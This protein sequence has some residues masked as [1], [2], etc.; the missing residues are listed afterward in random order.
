[1][2]VKV[3]EG[4][5]DCTGGLTDLLSREQDRRFRVQ[6]WRYVH[7]INPVKARRVWRAVRNRE[8]WR[9]AA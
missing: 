8:A 4:K 3:G 1:M 2:G 9:F 7:R 5:N 6:A